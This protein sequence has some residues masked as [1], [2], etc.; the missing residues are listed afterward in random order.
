LAT[1]SALQSATT[2]EIPTGTL[3]VTAENYA[4]GGDRGGGL[5]V[6]DNSA[7]PQ[8]A[9]GCISF[10]DAASRHWVRQ[11]NGSTL[12]VLQ[13]GANPDN[14]TDNAAAFQNGIVALLN[15]FGGGTLYLPAS[16][17]PSAPGTPNC[18]VTKSEVTL[19]SFSSF[20]TTGASGDG[21]TATITFSGSYL[22]PVGSKVT[23]T[24]VT[25]S[26]YNV[27]NAVVTVSTAGA[28]N[29]T[30][31]YA[32]TQT[33]AQT[34]A[35]VATY[36]YVTTSTSG[37]GSIATIGFAGAYLFPVGSNVTVSAVTPNYNTTNNTV[38][39]STLQA[40]GST[41]SYSKVTTGAQTVAG[42]VTVV[43]STGNPWDENNPFRVIGDG[44]AQTCWKFSPTGAD[45]FALAHS[46]VGATT[47]RNQ[48]AAV[49]IAGFT[50]VGPQSWTNQ[51]CGLGLDNITAPSVHDMWFE[52][53]VGTAN[54][55][56]PVGGCAIEVYGNRVGGS[57]GAHIFH[58]RFGVPQFSLTTMA[59]D[60]NTY[61]LYDINNTLQQVENR[62]AVWLNGPYNTGGKVNDIDFTEN[63]CEDYLI[64]CI[65]IAGSQ[66]S[67]GNGTQG[68]TLNFSSTGNQY[69]TYASQEMETGNISAES[70]PNVVTLRTIGSSY[71][72]SGTQLAGLTLEMEDLNAAWHSYYITT[73]GTSG[74]QVTLTPF[75]PVF[76]TTAN[77]G[78][79]QAV[80]GTTVT[81]A[82][83]ASTTN[84]FYSNGATF[85]ACPLSSS[86][87]I[88]FTS[89][90]C[91]GDTGVI[92]GYVGSTLVATASGGF[93]GC[94][95]SGT[96]TYV[97]G[98]QFIPIAV[99]GTAQSVTSSTVK[100][101][102][103]S[104]AVNNFY[105]NA[106]LTWTS[107]A[108]G[109]INQSGLI[110]VYVG[111]TTTATV[112]VSGCT[113]TGTPTY[114]IGT[115]YALG[116]SDVTSGTA[117][118]ATSTTAVL[119]VGSNS[120]NDYYKSSVFTWTTG[121]CAGDYA[122][123]SG[124]TGGSLTATI[125][126]TLPTACTEASGYG[127][128]ISYVPTDLP[129]AGA[130]GH[131][132][133]HAQTST[134]HSTKD[135]FERT[136]M[137]TASGSATGCVLQQP[138][139]GCVG[140]NAGMDFRVI[141]PENEVTRG[142]SAMYADGSFYMPSVLLS[143]A[144]TGSGPVST[145]GVI[146]SLILAQP[147]FVAN[148]APLMYLCINQTGATANIGDA[149]SLN[150]NGG[151]TG[152]NNCVTPATY[153]T[154]TTGAYPCYIVTAPSTAAGQSFAA[155]QPM[156]VAGPGSQVMAAVN[157]NGTAIAAGDLLLAQSTNDSGYT[158][159]VLTAIHPG[160]ATAQQEA[161]AC[162]YAVGTTTSM[163]A[164]GTLIRA[165]ARW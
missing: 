143:G 46:T 123:I 25:P 129:Y 134:G 51:A 15:N 119:Q 88:A 122:T 8:Q 126:A 141:D 54:L 80:S 101:Q 23:V 109:C 159:G 111:S 22:F 63:R 32:D 5:F 73:A 97:I 120:R 49:E 121:N 95:P 149:V 113:P 114:M 156:T 146:S 148:A 85:P 75:A 93:S 48:N 142:L 6:L 34:V 55:S 65:R 62:Y 150:A 110:T 151:G 135:Y 38:T 118:S 140:P 89:G 10:I 1:I 94:T 13:C 18:Y 44:P 61:T 11:L 37:T 125:P 60:G 53:F 21:S 7:S 2:T 161:Q 67:F 24:G 20:A 29:S 158:A 47:K 42:V 17:T 117:Q 52:G 27:T 16:Y 162:G 9:D 139:Q 76:T 78:T 165:L 87:T 3:S 98:T 79:A 133:F 72:Y 28:S 154:A 103:G 19:P 137:V 74:R 66:D 145:S 108:A 96:P 69:F 106:T 116:Y 26:G 100:L 124:Y 155:G 127:Y 35:G 91:A 163:A 77:S 40:S 130:I 68:S 64:G 115:N 56:D 138:P 104:S 83:G 81:L 131:A 45:P 90:N 102:A 160:S 71:L 112:S 4:T 82:P 70:S 12:S 58:N 164:A 136:L 99:S 30:V 128:T 105:T 57:F 31:S 107:G 43:P 152:R 59:A 14:T 153:S 39:A 92:T 36:G 86:C 157:P 50:L 147:G 41:V 132:F 33:G 144:A 84:S